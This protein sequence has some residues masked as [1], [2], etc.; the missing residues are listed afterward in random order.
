MKKVFVL[1]ALV[2]SL[3]SIG[4]G[5]SKVADLS[6]DPGVKP[7]AGIDAVYAQ[8]SR[9]YRELDHDLVGGLYSTDAS[10]LIPDQNVLIGREKI[11]PTFKSFFDYV[12]DRKGRLEISFRILQRR[13]A[14]D[15]AYDVGIY[16]LTNYDSAGKGTT[17]QGKFVVVAVKD[18]DAWR[19]QVDVYSDLPKPK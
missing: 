7:H 18:G 8:F 19:F 9:A 6:L 14:S 4:S 17:G 10:Y 3:S 15:L 2:F 12:K 5:Q 16:T 1:L 11:T 13:V